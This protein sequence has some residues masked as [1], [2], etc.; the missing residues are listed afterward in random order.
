M[1]TL[2]EPDAPT[3]TLRGREHEGEFPL[4]V[5]AL[6]CGHEAEALSYL[7]ARPLHT[8]YMAGLIH[9]NGLVNAHNRGTFYACRDAS[10][11]FAGLALI[12]HVTQIEARTGAALKAFARVAQQCSTAHVIMGVHEEVCAFWQHYAEAGQTLRLVCR[13]LL[14][15]QRRPVE[16]GEAVPEL[17]PATAAELPLV[18]PVQS[19]MAEAECGVNPLAV[20]PEGFRARCARRIARGRTWVVVEQGTLIFKADIMAETAEA[21]YLEGI[22]VNEQARGRRLGRRCLQQLGRILLSRAR[23]ICLLVNEQHQEA[24]A[25][26]LKA[27]YR[28]HSLYDTIYL[29]KG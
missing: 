27:G 6:A 16:A 10:G 18:L 7:A 26:Y 2:T 21:V 29:Y 23:A 13:E 12:G 22:Y 9:D 25:F 17:R 4:S 8:V 5:H 20:D 3:A 11:R 14:L 15:E 24:Q 28:V 19:G 1:Q